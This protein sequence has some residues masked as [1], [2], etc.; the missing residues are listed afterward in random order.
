MCRFWDL[1]RFFC[2][3]IYCVYVVSLHIESTDSMITYNYYVRLLRLRG[4]YVRTYYVV[5]KLHARRI[6]WFQ[7]V[8]VLVMQWVY[9]FSWK[10]TKIQMYRS[11]ALLGTCAYNST[12]RKYAPMSEM[13]L[14]NYKWDAP[15]N[16][17]LR[18][19]FHSKEALRGGR[20]V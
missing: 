7:L 16:A 14:I 2:I 15:N 19:F 10:Q 9:K 20:Y 11:C 5:L 17:R 13:R 12:G 8:E 18:Y 1:E 3:S 4:T 6:I